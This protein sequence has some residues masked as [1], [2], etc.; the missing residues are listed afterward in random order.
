MWRF[1]E[2][3][4]ASTPHV[5]FADT[6]L[7][8]S[9]RERL[10]PKSSYALLETSYP[11]LVLGSNSNERSMA[12]TSLLEQNIRDEMPFVYVNGLGDYN[13]FHRM[14]SLAELHGR[15][16]EMYVLNFLST[17]PGGDTFDPINPL[18]GDENAFLE[19][20]G[21][22]FGNLLHKVCL[23]EWLAGEL[24][25]TERFKSFLSLDNLGHMLEQDKYAGA[26]ETLEAYLSSLSKYGDVSCDALRL[27]ADTCDS[28]NIDAR[29][30][31]H[32][33]NVAKVLQFVELLDSLPIFST[34][35][36]VDFTQLF[37]SKK[38]VT[39]LLP[40]LE[41]DP[42]ALGFINTLFTCLISQHTPSFRK[43]SPYPAVVFDGC[44]DTQIVPEQILNRFECTNTLFT[45]CDH[46]RKDNPANSTFGTIAVMAEAII[47]MRMLPK[48]LSELLFAQLGPSNCTAWGPLVVIRGGTMRKLTGDCRF[49]FRQ[50]QSTFEGDE[51]LTQA[52]MSA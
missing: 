7:P 6:K 27:T 42:K 52:P 35:P 2:R 22:D 33:V 46:A 48:E 15:T 49:V 20:F 38:F 45:Y 44:F 30:L 19:L 9:L 26:K 12:I 36:T 13:Q 25:D 24:I 39:V 28:F 50:V 21:D 5:V 8:S 47:C 3:I 51:K 34:K 4:T 43:G 40:A 1:G 17:Q 29:V 14:H 41:K 10:A 11:V 37:K 23:C 16:E 32:V 31:Q 18:I